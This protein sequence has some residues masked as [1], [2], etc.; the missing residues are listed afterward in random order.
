MLL[1]AR[2]RGVGGVKPSVFSLFSPFHVW[3]ISDLHT[4]RTAA[5]AQLHTHCNTACNV[6]RRKADP[7]II[8]TASGVCTIRVENQQDDSSLSGAKRDA[9]GL[10]D[11]P[12]HTS[13][14]PIPESNSK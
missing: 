9:C 14:R 8:I 11:P 6:G 3:S 1:V 7:K 2:R 5:A 12:G 13:N 10:L 4:V